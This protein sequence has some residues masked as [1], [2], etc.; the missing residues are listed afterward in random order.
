MPEAVGH[1][2][3]V[4]DRCITCRLLKW[5]CSLPYDGDW[6]FSTQTACEKH[7]YNTG[8]ILDLDSQFETGDGSLEAFTPV[9]VPEARKLLFDHTKELSQEVNA[10]HASVRDKA[11]LL[12]GSTS[13]T[14]ALLSASVALVEKWH[15]DIPRWAIIVIF[16]AF[17][18]V[19]AH[20]V[21]ALILSIRAITREVSVSVPTQRV[22]DCLTGDEAAFRSGEVFQRLAAELR[23]A[24]AQSNRQALER[25][26]LVIVAQTSFRWGLT[27]LPFLYVLW[28]LLVLS[29]AET[30]RSRAVTDDQQSQSNVGIDGLFQDVNNRIAKSLSAVRED[31]SRLALDTRK[32]LHDIEEHQLDLST[33]I[34][35]LSTSGQ[36]LQAGVD[37]ARARFRED[38]A[39]IQSRFEASSML[40]EEQ[41]IELVKKV[42]DLTASIVK[43]DEG[44]GSNP[45][46]SGP[47]LSN[48]ASA[49]SGEGIA[50]Q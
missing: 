1:C 25:I 40:A 34:T 20:F 12:L 35:A 45:P 41:R 48:G 9:T 19:V 37:D 44:N 22:V 5:K 28:V 2:S 10:R 24:T 27:L 39:S 18:W 4:P 32:S 14:L 16:I 17:F 46:G 29:Y 3:E 43:M 6:I 50:P 33:S 26:N 7:I 30:P 13:L 31:L 38:L 42:D 11:K 21:R 8:A 36:R 23:A 15:S 49:R 47:Q